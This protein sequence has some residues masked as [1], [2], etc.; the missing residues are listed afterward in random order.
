MKKIPAHYLF[1]PEDAVPKMD[2]AKYDLYRKMASAVVRAIY[3]CDISY[4][5][6][7]EEFT[8][9][10][11]IFL[12]N[13]QKRRDTLVMGDAI[14]NL[15]ERRSYFLMKASLSRRFETIGG[16][17]TIRQK[18]HAKLL[19]QNVHVSPDITNEEER[20]RVLKQQIEEV[21]NH[22]D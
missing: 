2:L 12:P 4:V 5:S 19:K 7:P 13:H 20:K 3:S 21:R 14:H 18:E 10:S 15:L 9:G 8:Q 11:T 1:A 22:V 6:D 17:P 16:I